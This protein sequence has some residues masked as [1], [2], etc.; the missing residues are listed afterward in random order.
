M[1]FD[2]IKSAYKTIFI[3]APNTQ[4]FCSKL[5]V[6]FIKDP[7]KRSAFFENNKEQSSLKMMAQKIEFE[8][9]FDLIGK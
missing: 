8:R 7:Y 1:S 9:R 6:L 2:M 5:H 3:F 4:K